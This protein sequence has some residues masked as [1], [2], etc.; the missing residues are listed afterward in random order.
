ML[1][2]LLSLSQGHQDPVGQGGATCNL[3]TGNQSENLTVDTWTV[4][5]ASVGLGGLGFSPDITENNP[6]DDKKVET[7][8]TLE[9]IAWWVTAVL[10][11]HLSLQ[12]SRAERAHRKGGC[13][14]L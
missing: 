6:G 9:N 10:R 12:F 4:T 8:D 2:V 3:E 1:L 5:V 7:I 13:C 14:A 11:A